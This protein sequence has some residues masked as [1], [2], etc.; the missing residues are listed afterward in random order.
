VLTSEFPAT[1]AF[2]DCL[3]PPVHC[4]LQG[5]AAKYATPDVV[6]PRVW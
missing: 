2:G 3:P 4:W 5:I 6:V 1:S